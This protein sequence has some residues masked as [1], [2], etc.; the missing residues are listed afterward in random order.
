MTELC[1]TTFFWSDPERRRDYKFNHDHVRIL[2]NMVARNLSL[3]HRFVCVSDDEID[4]IETVKLD[5]SKHVPGTVFI[6][7]MQHRPD[8]ASI[9]GGERIFN[10]DLDIVVTRNIDHVVGRKED[11]VLFRNPNFP[12]PRRAF[13]QSSIQLFTAGARSQLWTDFDTRE[14]PKWVNWRFGGAEQAWISERLSW[15]ESYFDHRDGLY[16]AGRIGDWN[17]D[18]TADLPDNACIVTFPG[19]RMLDQPEVQRKFPWVLDHWK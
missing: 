3:P 5:W 11:I 17:N 4:D 13:Y 18:Q 2:R 14:T 1:V 12:S 7:L 9:I 6:R 16:G 8:Y 15:D 10:L 19:N